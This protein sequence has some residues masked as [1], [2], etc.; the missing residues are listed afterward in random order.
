M[1]GAAGRRPL[2]KRKRVNNSM[3]TIDQIL[4][5]DIAG[6]FDISRDAIES[7]I[8][9]LVKIRRYAEMRIN[10]LKGEEIL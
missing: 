7:E 10:E 2:G 8:A 4:E 1:A 3:D 6:R 9:D 5:S